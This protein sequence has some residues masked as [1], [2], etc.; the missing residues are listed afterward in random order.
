[1]DLLT[2][3]TAHYTELENLVPDIQSATGIIITTYKSGGKVLTCGN[4]GSAADAEHIVGE[5]LKSFE[6]ERPLTPE[7]EK[8]IRSYCPDDAPLFT[9]QLQMPLPAIALTAH[10]SFSTAFANDVQGE[11]VFAQQLLGLAKRGDTLIALSTSGNSENVVLAVKL[12]RALEIGTVGLTGREGGLL[13][14]LCD[15]CIKTPTEIT[16][17]AQEYHLAI[18]HAMCRIIERRFFE[19]VR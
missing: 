7:L 17:R 18:Y 8:A 15:V 6:V 12:A 2:E 14:D 19:P 9:Q 11:L 3:L 16:Y 13:G 1:M 5:L 4:G 10:P